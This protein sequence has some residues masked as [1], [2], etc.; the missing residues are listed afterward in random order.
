MI[1]LAKGNHGSTW[2][3]S[4]TGR[5]GCLMEWRARLCACENCASNRRISCKTDAPTCTNV[6]VT[7]L[8]QVVHDRLGDEDRQRLVGGDW[9]ERIDRCRRTTADRRVN[10]RIAIALAR[11][12]LHYVPDGEDRPRQAIDAAEAWLAGDAS[13]GGASVAAGGGGAGGG[14]GGGDL[15][16][17]LDLGLSAWEKAAADEG[18]LWEGETWAEEFCAFAEAWAKEREGS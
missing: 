16:D 6:V 9:A 13:G 12:V 7:A 8:A 1:Y 10:V 5:A 2:D 3:E 17:L 14:A 18:V 15:L 4:E 11:A